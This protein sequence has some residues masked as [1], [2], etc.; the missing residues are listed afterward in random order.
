MIVSL[1]FNLGILSII[2][3]FKPFLSMSELDIK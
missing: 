3:H 1:S 2:D